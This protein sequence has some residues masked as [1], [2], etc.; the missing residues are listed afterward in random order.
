MVRGERFNA[1]THIIGSVLALVG[2]SVV[3]TQASKHG[4]ARRITAVAV[5]GAMLVI[6]YLSSTLYHSLHGRAKRVFHVFDHCAIY[7]LIAGTYTPFTLVTL[8]GTWGWW[9]FSIVWSIAAAGVAKDA[10]FHGRYRALSV[11]LY[12]AMGWLV[13]VAF[14]PLT[15]ALP[16]PGILLLFAGGIVYTIGIFFFAMSKRIPYSHGVW[17]LFVIAGSTLHY[18]AVLRYVAM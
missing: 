10:I 7:L 1:I 11:M 17:H 15:H 13:V 18:L 14:S 9:L 2:T 3:I 4:D 8:R 16:R 6:L 5:Y 12:V